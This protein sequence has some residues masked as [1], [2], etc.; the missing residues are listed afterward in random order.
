MRP[1]VIKEFVE[2]TDFTGKKKSLQLASDDH[3]LYDMISILVTQDAMLSLL[4]TPVGKSSP[5]HLQ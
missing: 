1:I 5:G 3:R 2:D 4:Q